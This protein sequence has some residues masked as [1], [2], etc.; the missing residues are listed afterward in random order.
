MRRFFADSSDINDSAAIITGSDANH[1]R[2]VLRLKPGDNIRL[3][4]GS[5]FEYDA[6]ITAL[7]PGTVELSVSSKFY[8]STESPVQITIAQ[9]LLKEKKMDVL[10][11]QVTE[12]GIKQWIPFIAAR[13]VPRPDKERLNLRTER[14]KKIA[15]ESLKQCRRNQIPDI[16]ETASF[17]DMLN[18]GKDSDVKIIFWENENIPFSLFPDKMDYQKIFAVLGPE[19]G[20]TRDEVDAAKECGFV[21]GGLG[22][23]I[24]RAETAAVTACSLLQYIF[25]DMGKKRLDNE[26]NLD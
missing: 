12:L 26:M 15:K 8:S 6:V 13:S 19:G 9:A 11:R 2:N 23:R 4:D 24:L 18:I 10:I 5:G 21:T 25:G 1:I 7:S 16:A 22:P 17:E 14:W 20:F 3:F